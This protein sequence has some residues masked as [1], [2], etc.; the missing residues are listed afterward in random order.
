MQAHATI[1]T[2]L[3]V[4]RNWNIDYAAGKLQIDNACMQIEFVWCMQMRDACIVDVDGADDRTV[5]HVWPCGNSIV[6][7]IEPVI[8]S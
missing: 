1:K 3:S 8:P 4:V 5:Q 2:T 6:V 7:G